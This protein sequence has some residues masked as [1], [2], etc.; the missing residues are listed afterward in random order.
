MRVG[1]DEEDERRPIDLRN[2]QPVVLI[3]GVDEE[4]RGEPVT[5]VRRVHAV[6]AEDA[7]QEPGRQRGAEEV[8]RRGRQELK[9]AC[10][11]ATAMPWAATVVRITSLSALMWLLIM[12]CSAGSSTKSGFEKMLP[13]SSPSRTSNIAASV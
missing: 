12:A 3:Q 7:A 10:M 6:E 1:V 8:E 5:G 11:S 13:F 9:I 2:R 4:I